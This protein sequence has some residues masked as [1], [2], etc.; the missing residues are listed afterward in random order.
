V[1]ADDFRRIALALP[2]A[3][4]AGHMGHPDFRVRGKIFASLPEAAKGVLKLQPAQQEI[5]VAAEPGIFGPV[6]GYWGRSGWTFVTLVAAD[7]ATLKGALASA[8]R[9]T[10]PPKL[11]AKYEG[12]EA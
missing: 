10:A 7:E 4:E 8:W 2:E 9:N 3:V 1:T 11:I 6:N 5:M 12:A